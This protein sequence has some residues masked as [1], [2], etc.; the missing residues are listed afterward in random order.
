MTQA[1]TAAATDV[2][3]SGMNA[4]QRIAFIGKT[5]VFFCT[6]GFVFPTVLG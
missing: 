6:A 3:W 1:I 5:C 2:K 4:L